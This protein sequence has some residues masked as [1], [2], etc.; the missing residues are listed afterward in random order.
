MQSPT[1]SNNNN[2]KTLANK[3]TA[4][5]LLNGPKTSSITTKSTTV[6]NLNKPSTVNN[7]DLETSLE[8]EKIS[9][10]ISEHADAL[11]RT[12]KSHGL[13]PTEILELYTVDAGVAAG[14][15]TDDK[16]AE[17]L[18]KLVN[19]FVNKDKEQRGVKTSLNKN[20]LAPNNNNKTETQPKIIEHKIN[21]SSSHTST[22]KTN[23]AGLNNNIALTAATTSQQQLNSSALTV[24]KKTT[25]T[26]PT[27]TTSFLLKNSNSQSIGD[28]TDAG[29]TNHNT[30]PTKV[31]KLK[32]SK[33]S[34]G[35]ANLSDNGVLNAHTAPL[36]KSPLL[37]ANATTTTTTAALEK[38]SK[39]LEID[40]DINL[41]LD[42]NLDV[43]SLSQQQ[44]ENLL[45]I[46]E[47][48]KDPGSKVTPI[49]QLNAN[50]SKI[51]AALGGDSTTTAGKVKEVKVRKVASKQNEETP[52]QRKTNGS[53]IVQNAKKFGTKIKTIETPAAIAAN[54]A[55]IAM[56][57]Q[58]NTNQNANQLKAAKEGKINISD[59]SKDGLAQNNKKRIGGSGSGS[60]SSISS[61]SSSNCN[62]NTTSI[63]T[64]GNV[65][66]ATA[67]TPP[68]LEEIE[69]KSTTANQLAND[70][71]PATPAATVVKT[72]KSNVKTLKSTKLKEKSNVKETSKDP[73]DKQTID[74]SNN[75]P[76]T[77]AIILASTLT[78]NEKSATPTTISKEPKPKSETPEQTK[79]NVSDSHHHQNME[80]QRSNTSTTMPTPT[81]LKSS[82]P[83]TNGQDKSCKYSE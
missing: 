64:N 21:T 35:S 10:K 50:S 72:Q 24:Q 47:L 9:K 20:K 33:L 82:R 51:P 76:T 74:N 52:V 43:R 58:A 79:S 2:N 6:L 60:G 1:T 36:L 67:P 45:K 28:V 78:S 40:I 16:S 49:Q 11:Y 57:L 30:T 13:A 34:L 55:N 5:K 31:T 69:I 63:V 4:N 38:P 68:L 37:T 32:S 70:I 18:Q 39:P 7:C 17:D 54:A 22:S 46:K 44:T 14:A 26:S 59:N 83:L 71:T 19:T 66:N 77:A 8:I 53:E 62:S 73:N 81:K 25:T 65:T 41:N 15:I 80:I 42:L 61:I 23:T 12:W 56:T 75:R 27:K 29:L 3:T 48:L